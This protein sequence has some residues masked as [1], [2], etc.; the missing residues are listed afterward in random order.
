MDK[1][2]TKKRRV[3][4]VYNGIKE[5]RTQLSLRIRRDVY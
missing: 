2:K 1:L 4:Y 3:L 5:F